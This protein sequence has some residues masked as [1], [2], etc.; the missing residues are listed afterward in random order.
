MLNSEIVFFMCVVFTGVGDRLKY[1][2]ILADAIIAELVK[3]ALQ[4]AVTPESQFAAGQ[5]VYGIYILFA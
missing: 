1:F 5:L 2:S 4:P 3:R